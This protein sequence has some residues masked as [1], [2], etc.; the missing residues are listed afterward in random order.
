MSQST[1]RFKIVILVVVLTI[2]AICLG[3]WSLV[4]LVRN[5]V[6][7]S[8]LAESHVTAPA[9]GYQF[10]PLAEIASITVVE[11]YH[12]DGTTVS[13]FDVPE[14]CW[15]GIIESLSPSQYDSRPSPWVVLGSMVVKTRQGRKCEFDLFSVGSHSVF[16]EIDLLGAFSATPDLERRKYYRGGTTAKLRAAIERAYTVYRAEAGQLQASP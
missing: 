1:R 3:L 7:Q 12:D 8:L 2:A 10:P 16:P 14:P 13:Q 6:R 5:S 15:G 4:I 9:T 11:W